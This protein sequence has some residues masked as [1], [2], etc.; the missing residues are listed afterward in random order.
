MKQLRIC[1]ENLP[2]V[3]VSAHENRERIGSRE[4]LD[5]DE[6]LE[7][8]VEIIN[9]S[10]P[11]TLIIDALDEM[12]MEGRL[13]LLKAIKF[14]SNSIPVVKIF[15]SSRMSN[16]TESTLEN[17]PRI[18]IRARDNQKDIDKFITREI[19]K[20]ILERRL[21]GGSVHPESRDKIEEALSR[22]VDGM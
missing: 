19:D 13:E 14:I 12:E 20:A 10:Q 9:I 21:L 18:N 4:P 8:I 5:F 22:K 7:L 16:D 15:I 11:T 17:V 2:G 6:C 3:L 1:T